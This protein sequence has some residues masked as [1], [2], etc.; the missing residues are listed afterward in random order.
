MFFSAFGALYGLHMLVKLLCKVKAFFY[1]GSEAL[2]Q[3]LQI[4]VEQTVD[5]LVAIA[6]P[7]IDALQE[8]LALNDVHTVQIQTAEIV[9]IGLLCRADLLTV[10]EAF[11]NDIGFVGN[12]FYIP[13]LLQQGG[14]FFTGGGI[15]PLFDGTDMEQEGTQTILQ[16]GVDDQL[17]FPVKA[18]FHAFAVLL[19]K[20]LVGSRLGLIILNLLDL[21]YS[22]RLLLLCVIFYPLYHKTEK[23]AMKEAPVLQKE[24]YGMKNRIIRKHSYLPK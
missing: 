4:L 19:H 15:R 1:V 20:L 24:V 18:A 6:A 17:G 13:R 5:D 9:C 11:A 23:F 3:I 16:Q 2:A 21:R 12:V 8:L 22:H 14:H 10:T 7:V